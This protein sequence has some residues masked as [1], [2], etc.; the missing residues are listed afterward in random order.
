MNIEEE[1]DILID[2]IA[3]QLKSRMKKLV[4]RYEKQ[5]LRDY[6]TSVKKETSSKNSSS[7]SSKKKSE[8]VVSKKQLGRHKKETDYSSQESS[9]SD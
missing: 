8:S 4:L 5:V 7:S 1:V 6:I 9:D 3:A 2:K